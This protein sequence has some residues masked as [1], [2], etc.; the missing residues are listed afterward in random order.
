MSEILYRKKGRRY[1]KVGYEH[2]GFPAEGVWLVTKGKGM[3]SERIFT[4]I[5]DQPS[6]MTLA[7]FERHRDLIART[8]NRVGKN[9]HSLDE[10]DGEVS[11]AGAEGEE[12]RHV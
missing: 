11:K 9:L 7:A 12:K 5:G 2:V 4:R 8:I 6:V 3:R 1:E 10:M